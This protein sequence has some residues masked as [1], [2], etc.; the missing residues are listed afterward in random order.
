MSSRWFLPLFSVALGSIA[1]I[2]HIVALAALRI[3]S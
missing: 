1:V 3:R 2:A